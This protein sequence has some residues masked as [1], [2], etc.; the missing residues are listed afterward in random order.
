V[1]VY[2]SDEHYCSGCDYVIGVHTP[3]DSGDASYT[4]TATVDSTAMISLVH[5]RPQK[6]HLKPSTGR[7][8]YCAL[9]YVMLCC[10]YIFFVV[11][12]SMCV[13]TIL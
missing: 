7:C 5:G 3:G 13:W 12:Y 4:L 1:L 10:L 8:V 6:G 2:S 9:T 11:C